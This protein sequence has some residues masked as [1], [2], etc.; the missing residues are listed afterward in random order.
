MLS[1]KLWV[2]ALIALML[3]CTSVMSIKY[4]SLLILQVQPKLITCH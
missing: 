3:A 4:H 2:H 1:L